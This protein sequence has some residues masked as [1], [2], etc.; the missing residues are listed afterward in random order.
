MTDQTTKMTDTPQP[1]AG[2]FG[3]EILILDDDTMDRRRVTRM[4]RKLGT[5]VRLFGCKNLDEFKRALDCDAYDLCLIDYHL[6]GGQTGREAL[7]LIKGHHLNG[8]TP[9]IM[10]SSQKDS[11]VIVEAIQHGFSSYIEKDTLT[12]DRLQG[13]VHEALSETG[14]GRLPEET[15]KQLSQRIMRELADTCNN[16]AKPH[17]SQIYRQLEFIRNCVS[18]HAVPSPEALDQIEASCFEIWRFLDDLSANSGTKPDRRI[19]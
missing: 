12:V 10:I 15:M 2:D 4:A 3:L 8:F 19:H 5:N 7:E 1:D 11:D 14:T 13:A 16:H 17:L 9:A 6:G 18:K